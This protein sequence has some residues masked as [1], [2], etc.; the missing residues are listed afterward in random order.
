MVSFSHNIYS[1]D[2]D[3]YQRENNNRNIR[4]LTQRMKRLIRD[5]SLGN[6]L[7]PQQFNFNNISHNMIYY[8]ASEEGKKQLY[9][10]NIRNADEA[11]ILACLIFDREKLQNLVVAN[12][13]AGSL[14][15][16]YNLFQHANL[17]DT[18]LFLDKIY[19]E[20]SQWYIIDRRRHPETLGQQI[21][22]PIT[23]RYI[24]NIN[25]DGNRRNYKNI[26]GNIKLRKVIYDN[27]ENYHIINYEVKDY[28]VVNF[29]EN[30]LLEKEYNIIKD[31]LN[32]IKMPT[33]LELTILLNKIDYNLNVFIL[34]GEQ[35]Q[36][37]NEYSKT[38]NI[39]I[40]DEHMY[41]LNYFKNA[42]S[43]TFNKSYKKIELVD[44]KKFDSIKTPEIYN[45]NIK[46]INGIKYK[47]ENL[48]S[49]IDRELN[50][51]RTSFSHN[52]IDFFDSC[53]I[54]PIRY[55][56]N[57]E[58][59]KLIQALDINSCYQNI[60][61]NKNY[62][63]PQHNGTEETEIFNKKDIILRYGFYYVEWNNKE[64]IF[65]ILFGTQNKLWIF[66]DII[67][68][69]KIQKKIKIIYKHIPYNYTQYF[70]HLP[71]YTKEERKERKIMDTLYTG[72]LA[73][74][75]KNKST[76]Y[77]CSGDEAEALYKK[78]EEQNEIVSI[79]KAQIYTTY[80]DEK[81]KLKQKTEYFN[82]NEEKIKIY[83][84]CVK[85]NNAKINITDTNIKID[86]DYFVQSAGLYAYLA[87]I[88]YARYQLY[89]I[90]YEVKKLYPDIIVKKIY[91]DSITFNHK[92]NDNMTQFTNDINKKLEKYEIAVKPEI[93]N[94]TWTHN[95][96][97]TTE[98]IIKEKQEIKIHDN[99]KNLLDYEMSFC[100][101]SRAGY[102]KTYTINN[103]IIPYFNRN[104]LNYR[105]SSTTISDAKNHN[106]QTINSLIACNDASLNSIINEFKNVDYLIIDECSR[107]NMNLI[108][109]LQY[110]KRNNNNIKFIFIG[111]EYQ[112]QYNTLNKNIMKINVFLDLIDYNFYNIKWHEK[113]R[114]TKEYDEFLN[115]LITL[116]NTEERNK[117]IKSYFKN[118]IKKIG[119]EDNNKIKISY[120]NKTADKIKGHTIHHTQGMT[121]NEN[122]SIYEIEKSP[123]EVAYT[124]LSRITNPKFI[125]LFF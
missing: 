22:N 40:H 80:R 91:T 56:N 65:N 1:P 52:N 122:L 46:M 14:L 25:V 77:K 71:S 113:A 73:M 117:F 49:N 53:N 4:I 102:G 37:Q 108:N 87:I 6:I 17:V 10:I 13:L 105:I 3:E 114:Y 19:N 9:T 48:F 96:L 50:N 2:D 110:L 60:M 51:L 79:E 23:G 115:K 44:N 45:H 84:E 99:L 76:H 15:K 75:T 18:S 5:N 118:Q 85:L 74:R 42:T 62:V 123:L 104:K 98:P 43:S 34:D 90:Y 107:L 36:K 47:K 81:N 38:F 78:Y 83:E 89:Q 12:R 33:Y 92:L 101:N 86:N 106:S 68:M 124:A 93:S 59:I 57:D 82:T 24:Y 120:T 16:S 67:L 111:D 61:Y 28:C 70:S 20:L 21:R 66:G 64:E 54:R 121:I 39:M 95:E 116:N 100:I 125:T 26:F 103:V 55:I 72:I 109:V 94:Y 8:R 11:L 119:D 88:S 27:L 97:I 35:I 41:V 29:L 32:K 31:E 7:N 30:K 63:F 112:C 58:N 69:L